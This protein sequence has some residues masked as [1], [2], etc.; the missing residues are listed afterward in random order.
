MKLTASKAT[1]ALAISS[2][3]ALTACGGGDDD[4]SASTKGSTTLTA[5]SIT[6]VNSKD[7]A[8]QAYSASAGMNSQV[9]SGSSLVTTVSTDNATNGLLDAALNRVHAA[10]KNLPATPVSGGNTTETVSCSGGGNLTLTVN[11]T[12]PASF[13]KGDSSAISATNCAEGATALN[14]ALNITFN[15][16]T[17]TPSETSAGSG[18]LGMTF[19]N[20]TVNDDL[21]SY[22]ATGDMSLTVNQ[23]DLNTTHFTA[24]GDSLKIR[25]V[26]G[27]A[28]TEHSMTGYSY[29]GSLNS[30]DE[31][32]YRA[33]F[34]L[35]GNVAKPGNAVYVVQTTTDFQQQRG[36]YPSQGGLT[37]TADDKSALTLTVVDST[38]AQIGIDTNGDGTIDETTTTTWAELAELL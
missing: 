3:L 14:G 20:F 37:V 36:S 27:S 35:N 24:T 30:S 11:A 31:Y 25:T 8:A 16:V 29:S 15:S 38:S 32:T 17:G 9:V 23:A 1:F 7:V 6:L 5:S 13:S 33:N 2:T 18:I 10:L 22:S 26:K 28:T 12:N 19:N 4:S 21:T 34:T